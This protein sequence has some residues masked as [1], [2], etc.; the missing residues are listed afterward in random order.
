MKMI[1]NSILFFIFLPVLLYSQEDDFQT[2]LSTS[3]KQK[4]SKKSDFYLRN[5]IRLRENSSLLSKVFTDVK[6]KYKYK[7]KLYFAIG[8][9]DINE[10]DIQLERENKERFYADIYIRK[11]TGRLIFLIRNRLQ[12]QGK[13]KHYDYLFRQ[14][15]TLDY[16]LRGTKLT[17]SMSTEYFYHYIDKIN[18]LRHSLT[19]SFPFSKRIDFNV[20]YRI[21]KQLNV[22]NPLDIYILD[23]KISY[24]L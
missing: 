20:S 21:Q 2:W 17:P 3:V 4:I 23:G 22:A 24:N 14:R 13:F 11:K 19:I 9:R 10:W 1:R 16:N 8:Y 5:S 15:Y 6:I 18:K 7:K 12:K